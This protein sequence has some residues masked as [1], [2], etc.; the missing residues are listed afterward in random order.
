VGG[1]VQSASYLHAGANCMTNSDTSLEAPQ[2]DGVEGLARRPPRL[3]GVVPPTAVS[4]SALAQATETARA[5]PGSAPASLRSAAPESACSLNYDDN[6]ASSGGRR[7]A[8][9]DCHRARK[10]QF[11]ESTTV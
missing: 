9:A 11:G 1:A 3:A 4:S 5:L 6:V 10:V 7:A 8:A 2:A